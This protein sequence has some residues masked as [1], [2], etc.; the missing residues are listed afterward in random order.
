VRHALEAK[1]DAVVD[2]ALSAHSRAHARRLQKIGD[3][4]L[5]DAGA[6]A[7]FDV[8]LRSSFDDDRVDSFEVQEMSEE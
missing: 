7:L 2:Q 3:P 6:H 4:P 8:L 5:D 1:F